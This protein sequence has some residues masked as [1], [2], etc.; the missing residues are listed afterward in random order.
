MTINVI[1]QFI[2]VWEQKANEYYKGILEIPYE[3]RVSM[4]RK[5]EMTKSDLQFTTHQTANS[6]AK[7]IKLEASKRLAKLYKQ[8]NAKVGDIVEC[9]LETN[10]NNG[11]DGVIVGTEATANIHTVLAGG[12]NIQCLH[13]RTLIKVIKE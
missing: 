3:T 1:E 12:D 5:G 11:F 4:V 9:D 6:L 13:Y 7:E 2:Q 10:K 8:I